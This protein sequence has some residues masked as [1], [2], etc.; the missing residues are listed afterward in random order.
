M[1]VFFRLKNLVW[2]CLFY[3]VDFTNSFCTRRSQRQKDC[4]FVLLVSERLK[5][6]ENI[7]VYPGIYTGRPYCWYVVIGTFVSLSHLFLLPILSLDG[8]HSKSGFIAV[9]VPCC[10]YL[11]F[12]WYWDYGSSRFQLLFRYH[13]RS[14]WLA[15]KN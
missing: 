8:C 14:C 3:Q 4:P 15:D 12:N 11:R 9:Q 7:L 6:R 2:K 5:L 1:Q 10:F 13:H